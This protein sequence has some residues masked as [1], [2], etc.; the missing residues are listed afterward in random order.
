MF[1]Y[2]GIARKI[3]Q[4][5]NGKLIL[6]TASFSFHC[7][8]P[9]TLLP[10]FTNYVNGWPKHTFEGPCWNIDVRLVFDE[11]VLLIKRFFSIL[12][13]SVAFALRICYMCIIFY[14]KKKASGWRKQT[15]ILNFLVT[16]YLLLWEAYIALR[17]EVSIS[18][19][20]QA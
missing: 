9:Q 17:C 3:W 20:G 10:A 7:W 2:W 16:V 4:K 13:N 8:S 15:K 6:E 11:A 12:F 19:C 14:H 1:R 5:K 18:Q